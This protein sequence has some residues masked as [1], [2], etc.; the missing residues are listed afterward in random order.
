MDKL[1]YNRFTE[2]INSAT[3]REHVRNLIDTGV[4]APT[5]EEM[6]SITNKSVRPLTEKRDFM[7]SLLEYVEDKA[8]AQELRRSYAMFAEL[9]DDI[10]LR[11]VEVN[12][13][14]DKWASWGGFALINTPTGWVNRLETDDICIELVD[15]GVA[16]VRIKS[17]SYA[18]EFMRRRGLRFISTGAF[19]VDS[20]G[21]SSH[22]GEVRLFDGKIC[23]FRTGKD[24]VD[25]LLNAPVHIP[26]PFSIG[27]RVSPF[28]E[29]E[30]TDEKCCI[31]TDAE[32]I[33]GVCGELCAVRAEDWDGY[34]CR[35]CRSGLSDDELDTLADELSADGIAIL[36]AELVEKGSFPDQLGY[37]NEYMYGLFTDMLDCIPSRTLRAHFEQQYNDCGF[38]PSPEEMLCIAFNSACSLEQKYKFL[39]KIALI[40]SDRQAA[41]HIQK[42]MEDLLDFDKDHMLLVPEGD[43]SIFEDILS[44]D[45]AAWDDD[46][47]A[48]VIDDD[49]QWFDDDPDDFFGLSN[50]DD[51]EQWFDDSD[52]NVD[53]DDFFDISNK[54]LGNM[55]KT[56]IP[57]VQFNGFADNKDSDALSD[58][59]SDTYFEAIRRRVAEGTMRR[60]AVLLERGMFSGFDAVATVN[61]DVNGN[62]KGFTPYDESAARLLS[63]VA[64]FSCPFSEGDIVYETGNPE[65]KYVICKMI[66]EDKSVG[67]DCIEAMPLTDSDEPQIPVLLN[68]TAIELYEDVSE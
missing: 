33:D 45:D 21:A 10:E 43:E 38:R 65:L 11:Y 52:D 18:E 62:I 29:N 2:Y 46:D 7:M 6:L 57:Q 41:V 9:S 64:E 47:D 23:G 1:I 25:K 28:W 40:I 32:S 48:F 16:Y 22:L 13:S 42:I 12:T 51:D 17:A 59:T 66:Q 53:V 50:D 31:V 19:S 4:F 61:F 3:M 36:D 63:T 20:F 60:R 54:S 49:E 35:L 27:D 5:A 14:A 68:I 37:M 24:E 58:D 67:F 39:R 30:R 44:E 26:L 34:L 55:P 8:A 56:N 15:Y